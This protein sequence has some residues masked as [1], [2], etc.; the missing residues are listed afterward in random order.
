MTPP[1][2]A[3]SS[4]LLALSVFA[5]PSRRAPNVT[6]LS[7]PPAALVVQVSRLLPRAVGSDLLRPVEQ[8]RVD[9]IA[10]A[11][12]R[13]RYTTLGGSKHPG[14]L[15]VP[16]LSFILLRSEISRRDIVQHIVV[17]FAT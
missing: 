15:S 16:A 12:R 4:A 11:F 17:D 6:Q 8:L 10:F 7:A 9:A 14:D 5:T 13:N 2:R 3:H 1:F